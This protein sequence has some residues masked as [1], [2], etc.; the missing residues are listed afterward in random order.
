MP[1]QDISFNLSVSF[2]AHIQTWPDCTPWTCEQ[3]HATLFT[4][5]VHNNV[6]AHLDL[7][8]LLHTLTEASFHIYY[9]GRGGKRCKEWDTKLI[10]AKGEGFGEGAPSR[11]YNFT[12]KIGTFVKIKFKDFHWSYEGYTSEGA[13]TE[14]PRGAGF[15]GSPSPAD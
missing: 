10:R 1:Q 9:V 13:R 15:L 2:M 5:Y 8:Q 11:V 14:A 3:Q 12:W 7:G 4:S 6:C